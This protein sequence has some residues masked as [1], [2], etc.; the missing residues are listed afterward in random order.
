AQPDPVRAGRAGR[1]DLVGAR[2]RDRDRRRYRTTAPAPVHRQRPGLRAGPRAQRRLTRRRGTG[3]PWFIAMTS[4][5]RTY[6]VRTY[7]CQMNVHD[8]ERISG[9][10]ED[11][12][13][14]RAT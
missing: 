5:P 14:V 13:Y 2:R 11:A 9:L 8:S 4:T 6:D 3:L 7:G 12:G 1:H 10:M